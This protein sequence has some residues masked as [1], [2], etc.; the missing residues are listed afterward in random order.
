MTRGRGFEFRLCLGR[1]R[2][3]PASGVSGV[4]VAPNFNF[5]NFIG[6]I[7]LITVLT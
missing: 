1:F 2:P 4:R 6:F 5:V 7:R 3:A